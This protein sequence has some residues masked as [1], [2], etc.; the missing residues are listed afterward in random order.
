MGEIESKATVVVSETRLPYTVPV[1]VIVRSVQIILLGAALFAVY[2]CLQD[3]KGTDLGSWIMTALFLALGVYFQF[4]SSGL[5]FDAERIVHR[6]FIGKKREIRWTEIAS[7]RTGTQDSPIFRF[8]G[9]VA[10]SLVG[11]VIGQPVREGS[12]FGRVD[13]NRG[14]YLMILGR[15]HGQPPFIL[16]IKPYSMKGLIKLAYFIIH[17]VDNAVVDEATLNLTKGIVPSVFFGEQK[18]HG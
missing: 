13:P 10:A 4:R 15:R 7:A 11:E 16:S 8:Y 5:S 1:D 2:G 17:K 6:D 18:G 14:P 12:T 3:P 9:G